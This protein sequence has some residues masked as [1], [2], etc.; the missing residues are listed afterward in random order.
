MHFFTNYIIY[1]LI[2]IAATG[3]ALWSIFAGPSIVAHL[4]RKY[5][6][7]RRIAWVS[8][9][10]VM[11]CTAMVLVVISV[12]GGWLRMFRTQFH[13]LVGDVIV[14][15]DSLTGFPH[16]QE[17]IDRI[18]QLPEVE[19]AV[20]VIESF[21]LINIHNLSRQGVRVV[22]Y[23][24]EGIGEVNDFPQ[25]LYLHYQRYTDRADDP[26]LSPQQREDARRLAEQ[27][28]SAP[29]FQKPLSDDDYRAIAPARG[30]PSRWAGMIVGAGVVG[31]KKERDG[32]IKRS[33]RL[34][35]RWVHL[36]TVAVNPDTTSPDLATDKGEERFWIVDDSRT[37]IWQ[38]DSNTVYVPFDI[39]QRMLKMDAVEA[40]IADTGE[41]V[42]EPART[43]Q[44][45]IGVKDGHD[46]YAVKEKVKRVVDTV[47][48]ERGIPLMYPISVETWEESQALFLEAIEK[49][50]VLV[51]FLFGII[52]VV[53]VFL[54]FC[55]FYMIVVEKTKDIGIIKSVGAT[56]EGVAGIFLGY[57]M[58]I[59]IVGAALGLLVSWL[60]VDNINFLHHKM[61]ELMGVQIWSPEVYAFDTIPDTMDPAT[62]IIICIVAV[63]AS[64]IGSL[65]PA[66]RAARMNPV[67]ALRWE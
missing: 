42:I 55:I 54:I 51:T 19:A 7:K 45:H 48:L 26:N 63:I 53:A 22:G 64:V 47:A 57:G 36:T 33:P 31:L 41:K 3:F 28:R 8:L 4:I 29:L 14:E 17:M 44:I 59:G 37:K 12:M 56:S 15:G 1:V 65:V 21:G 25:S 30:D 24:G 39:L 6:L 38:S 58:A 43:S 50:V 11:L 49:E 13:G 23:P 2:G 9:V 40:T 34:Y 67:E 35:E 5:L 46:L 27:A 20:P 18:R 60:I 16:Y 66:I 61:G 52:S 62:V 10:A 32:T